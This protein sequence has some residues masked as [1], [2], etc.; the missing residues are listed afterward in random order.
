M[1][2]CSVDS[3]PFSG[4]VLRRWLGN[5]VKYILRLQ[6]KFPGY[7]PGWPRHFPFPP[8]TWERPGFS[9]SSPP[10]FGR[11]AALLFWFLACISAWFCISPNLQRPQWLVML[12]T[13]PCASLPR[14]HPLGGD[15]LISF[16]HFPVGLFYYC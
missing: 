7:K 16:V 9:P 8:A 11:A 14:A 4:E 15:L 5:M 13:F 6:K 1:T 3:F 2:G 12:S 10:L